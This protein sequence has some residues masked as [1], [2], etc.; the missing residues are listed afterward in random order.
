MK[1]RN[2]FIKLSVHSVESDYVSPTPIRNSSLKKK[3]KHDVKNEREALGL[4]LQFRPFFLSLNIVLFCIPLS[5]FDFFYIIVFS[6][7][8]D[9]GLFS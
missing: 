7:I 8:F 6:P 1:I 3:K 4:V 9:G 5:S 2:F